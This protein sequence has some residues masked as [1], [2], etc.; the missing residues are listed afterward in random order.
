MLGVLPDTVTIPVNGYK[1]NWVFDVVCVAQCS[2]NTYE[3][4]R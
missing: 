1:E 2:E 4:F 3:R